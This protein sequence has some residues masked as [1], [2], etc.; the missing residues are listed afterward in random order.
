MQTHHDGVAWTM[1]GSSAVELRDMRISIRCLV[2]LATEVFGKGTAGGEVAR[3]GSV[4]GRRVQR[5]SFDN[6]NA[7]VADQ[8]SSVGQI[9][10]DALNELVIGNVVKTLINAVDAISSRVQ[11]PHAWSRPARI[12]ELVARVRLSTGCHTSDRAVLARLFIT[13]LYGIVPHSP[14]LHYITSILTALG[15]PVFSASSSGEVLI[16]IKSSE[17]KLTVEDL[18]RKFAADKKILTGWWAG[19]DDTT[20]HMALTVL[21]L[22]SIDD[23]SH[24]VSIPQFL[25]TLCK[26]PRMLEHPFWEKHIILRPPLERLTGSLLGVCDEH[27][28]VAKLEAAA[29]AVL[30]AN[31]RKQTKKK[32]H[33]ISAVAHALVIHQTPM[34]ALDPKQ[35]ATLQHEMMSYLPSFLLEGSSKALTVS[36]KMMLSSS[37]D[38]LAATSSAGAK[39]AIPV[40]SPAPVPA[41]SADGSASAQVPG[42]V[43]TG[44]V[45]FSV[46][47][48]VSSLSEVKGKRLSKSQLL[49]LLQET[50]ASEKGLGAVNCSTEAELKTQLLEHVWT[51]A[52]ARPLIGRVDIC[53]FQPYGRWFIIFVCPLLFRQV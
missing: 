45:G 46:T 36:A 43:S 32:K 16:S 20:T 17:Q 52:T 15:R 35:V 38:A 48:G 26:S 24:M 21:C 3:R 37:E 13:L 9:A 41:S 49:W 31:E 51:A 8:A 18:M 14:P 5:S 53:V 27:D 2:A 50:L 44:S 40:P 1:G 4:D 12:R 19:S 23:K 34:Q 39:V 25:L 42:V 30:A 22:C 6:G 33:S 28:F 11:L 47:A 29:A 7:A 10:E